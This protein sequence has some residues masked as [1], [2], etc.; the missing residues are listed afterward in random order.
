MDGQGHSGA[1]EPGWVVAASAAPNATHRPPNAHHMPGGSR[2]AAS[3]SPALAGGP[4]YRRHVEW[5]RASPWEG[6]AG[7]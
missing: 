5:P 7:A 3:A 4:N 1:A 6:M 2:M